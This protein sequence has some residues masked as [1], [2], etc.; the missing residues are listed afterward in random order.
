MSSDDLPE[1]T[2]I[3]SVNTFGNETT[4]HGVRYMI[5]RGHFLFRLCWLAIIVLAFTL[6]VI[7]AFNVYGDYASSPYSTKINIVQQTFK[8]FPAVTVC[9][10][11]RI[12]RSMLY[13]T[14]YEVLIDID[15]H[16]VYDLSADINRSEMLYDTNYEG[17]IDTDEHDVY[18][19][20]ADNNRSESEV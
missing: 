13:D 3:G 7:Q 17:L 6:F 12:R 18:D 14:N 16:D 5:A 1:K 9:N 11:N 10:A 8:A 20:S 19:S 4:V 15:E 2:V